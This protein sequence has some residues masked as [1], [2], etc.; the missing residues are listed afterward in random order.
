MN[1]GVTEADRFYGDPVVRFRAMAD[2]QT[3]D[4]IDIAHFKM[5]CRIAADEIETARR[6]AAEP[7]AAEMVLVPREPTPD[8]ISAASHVPTP[9]EPGSFDPY[10]EELYRAFLAA[11]P[12]QSGESGK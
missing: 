8:M 1:R 5:W 4:P 9:E 6:L 10:W 11:A 2:A 3:V 12:H 7:G